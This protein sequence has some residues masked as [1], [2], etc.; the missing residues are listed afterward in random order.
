MG[1]NQS[2]L[3]GLHHVPVRILKNMC[4]LLF[5]GTTKPL[6]RKKWDKDAPDISIEPLAE[7]HATV[8]THFTNPEVQYIGS[9]SGCGC[10]FPNVTLLNGEWRI[11]EDTREDVARDRYN[12]QAL[13]NL[14]RATGEKMI[15]LY[16]IWDGDFAKPPQAREDIPLKCLLDGDFSFKEQGFYRVDIEE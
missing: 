7:G 1:V 15:E 5:A 6:P 3:G 9:T 12:Q 4:F 2:D 10:D 16:G 8:K 13:V 14:L 11:F